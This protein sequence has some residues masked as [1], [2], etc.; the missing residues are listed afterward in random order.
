MGPWGGPLGPWG[1]AERLAEE[2]T[3]HG[4]RIPVR[5]KDPRLP[6]PEEIK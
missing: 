1:G 2:Q 3:E 6:S 4:S 5:I